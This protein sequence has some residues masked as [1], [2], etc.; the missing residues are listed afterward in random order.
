M[1]S[2]L[3]INQ[4]TETYYD[5]LSTRVP[6][7]LHC[8]PNHQPR[9]CHTKDWASALEQGASRKHTRR[10]PVPAHHP[11]ADDHNPRDTITREL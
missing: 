4:K 8:L 5:V 6:Q 7:Q 2:A 3:L 1:Q 10:Q 11:D 9:P